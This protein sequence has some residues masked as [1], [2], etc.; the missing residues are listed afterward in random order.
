MPQIAAGAVGVIANEIVHAKARLGAAAG[1]GESL[2]SWA[3]GFW[4]H[5]Y[6]VAH[7]M[8]NHVVNS[9]SIE[10]NR[11]ARP[12]RTIR[13]LTQTRPSFES[14]RATKFNP[15][16]SVTLGALPQCGRAACFFV[17]TISG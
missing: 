4:L 1:R 14:G 16:T 11:R 2:R 12:V 15:A 13:K 7:G 5:R 8:T 17:S 10:M 3:R 6:L 9:S